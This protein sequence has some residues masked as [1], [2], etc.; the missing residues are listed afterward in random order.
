MLGA[1]TIVCAVLILGA[2]SIVRA[3]QV[4]ADPWIKM[5]LRAG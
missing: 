2:A 5:M 3:G 4:V 1:L